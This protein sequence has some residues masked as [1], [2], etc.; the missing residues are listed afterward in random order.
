MG[1]FKTFKVLLII[2]FLT[3]T[4]YV[5]LRFY[6][7][8]RIQS[9]LDFYAEQENIARQ[10][11]SKE[12][13][14]ELP[15][16]NLNQERIKML[17]IEGGGAKGLFAIRVLDYLEKKTGKPVSQLYGVMGGTSIGSLLTSILSIPGEKG[18]KYSAEEVLKVFAKGAEE[19]LEPQALH[20]IFSGFGLFSPVLE[21]QKYI[22]SLRKAYGDTLFSEALN[23]LIL[24]GF[25]LNTTKVMIM[26]NR[27]ESL[28][29]C[30]P[31]LYQLIGGTT[32]AY[33]ISPSNRVLLNNGGEGQ[34]LIDAGL[35]VNNPLLSMVFQINKLYPQKKVLVTY[36]SLHSKEL[37]YRKDVQFYV[38]EIGSLNEYSLMILQGRNQLINEYMETLTLD[39]GFAF[40][41]L[42]EIGAKQDTKWE[43][44]NPFNFSKQNLK[45][46]DDFAIEIVKRNQKALDAVAEELLKD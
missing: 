39:K 1:R 16:L 4:F 27:G 33:G 6:Q 42:T 28:K 17:V 20:K 2:F 43:N 29:N 18:P 32:A 7:S 23:H 36:I 19:A 14:K 34:F 21:S 10:V 24:Y 38:G 8:H 44:L 37:A 46:I 11:F 35:I 5:V 12:N 30:N 31:V 3:G 25:N 40:D 9:Y 26:N 41:Y 45:I 22:E 15:Q 13:S